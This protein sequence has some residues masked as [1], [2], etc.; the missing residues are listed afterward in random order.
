MSRETSLAWLAGFFE[1]EGHISIN[2]T[3]W[4]GTVGITQKNGRLV[5][6]IIELVR[7]LRLPTP[8]I[9]QPTE[10]MSC[11]TLVWSCMKGTQFL[12][13]IRPY[14]HHPHKMARADIY[15]QFFRLEDAYKKRVKEGDRRE[16]QLLFAQ[17]ELQQQME[18]EEREKKPKRITVGLSKVMVVKGP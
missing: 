11:Y 1:G 15:L 3:Q 8:S 18:Q 6:H 12:Q 7:L 17:F 2:K 14:F 9:S 16:R 5:R 13:A 4:G 10:R